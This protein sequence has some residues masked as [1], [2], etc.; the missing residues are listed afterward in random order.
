MKKYLFILLTILLMLTVP[1]AIAEAVDAAPD[2][3]Y[4]WTQLATIAGATA[5]TLLIV[6]FI[7]LPLDKVW[8][9]P[10]RAIVYV[11]ALLIMIGA[12]AFTAGLQLEDI[13][14]LAIN[15]FVVAL[16]AMGSYEMTFAKKE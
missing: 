8:K 13:P 15:A 2:T 9:V 12:R 4:D 7:K 5:A 10:T 6:Q 3:A 14:L 11:I 1:V 16:A